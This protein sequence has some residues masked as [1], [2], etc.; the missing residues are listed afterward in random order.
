M[1]NELDFVE[2]F[3]QETYVEDASDSELP[4]WVQDNNVKSR[5]HAYSKSLK[6]ESKQ[7]LNQ[8]NRRLVGSSVVD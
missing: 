5:G 3:I 2:Q 7:Y 8:R 1:F 6:V 4:K